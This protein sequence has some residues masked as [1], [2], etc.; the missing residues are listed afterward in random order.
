[1]FG[2]FDDLVKQGF[3]IDEILKQFKTVTYRASI[4]SE[5]MKAKESKM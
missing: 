3:N 2:C 5:E 1:M 4:Y